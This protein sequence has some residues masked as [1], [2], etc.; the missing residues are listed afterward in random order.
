MERHVDEARDVL[1]S[2][3]IGPL[4]FTQITEGRRR[5]HAF[6]ARSRSMRRSLE[7]SICQVQ[8]RILWGIGFMSHVTNRIALSEGPLSIF[9]LDGALVV[10]ALPDTYCPDPTDPNCAGGGRV[11]CGV[12]TPIQ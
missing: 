5:G 9:D 10:H 3:L 8:P 6:E 11:A 1:R 4:V 7:W 12:I 2:L